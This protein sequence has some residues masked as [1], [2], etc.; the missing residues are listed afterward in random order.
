MVSPSLN[1]HRTSFS[2][3]RRSRDPTTKGSYAVYAAIILGPG[4]R[5]ANTTAKKNA[6]F[7]DSQYPR[8]E[9]S[10]PMHIGYPKQHVRPHCQKWPKAVLSLRS[11]TLFR[12]LGCQTISNH[13]HINMEVS[14]RWNWEA[15][16]FNLLVTTFSALMSNSSALRR[17]FMMAHKVIRTCDEDERMVLSLYYGK[18]W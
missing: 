12:L 11:S 13:G 15:E 10:S 18:I 7:F 8:T 2:S 6:I 17:I 5:Q 1:Y 16:L 9:I 3:F 14:P 4:S